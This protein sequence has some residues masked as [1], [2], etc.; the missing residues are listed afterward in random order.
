[1]GTGAT[2][3]TGGSNGKRSNRGFTSVTGKSYYNASQDNNK[4]GI[5]L[6]V[7]SD[8][9]IVYTPY[10]DVVS[11][12]N[13]KK[14]VAYPL[15]PNTIKNVQ[16]GSVVPLVI[17]PVQLSQGNGRDLYKQYDQTTYY[18]DPIV[19]GP[20]PN[21][22]EVINPLTDANNNIP[23]NVGSD[24][25]TTGLGQKVG[26]KAS[27]IIETVYKPALEKAFPGTNIVSPPLKLLMCAQ[28][29]LEGFKPGTLAYRT[30][31]PG[32][33]GT[34]NAP[35]NP[36]ITTFKTL[37]EGVK[38]QWNKVLKGALANTSKYYKSNFTLYQYL[39]TY[40]PPPENDPV[41]YTNFVVSYMNKFG[42]PQVTAQTTLEEL[43]KLV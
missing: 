24:Y 40:A 43:S 33:V 41:S 6:N 31:N 11:V 34:H 25:N 20:G 7:A 27:T 17:G 1:M 23:S 4:Y 36:K 28:T 37:E 8:K 13:E 35:P 42:Y 22:N 16:P 39:Y 38:A 12:G 18:L 10:G 29:T 3:K 30:N 32:N 2:I 14:G 26:V 21:G 19:M 5:V 15:Y 9:S